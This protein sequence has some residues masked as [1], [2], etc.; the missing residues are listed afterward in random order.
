[1][2][3]YALVTPARN[4][5]ENLRRLGNAL[6]EQTVVPAEWIVVDD[7]STDETGS[8]VEGFRAGRPWIRLLGPQPESSG[9][10]LALGRLTGRDVYAFSR[11]V[12]A[13]QSDADVIVKLDADV[14]F[15]PDFFA[16]LLSE[17]ERDPTLG[18]AGGLCLE[19]IDGEW[20]P[21]HT[22]GDHVRGATRA[23][24]RECLRLVLPLAPRL[25][26]DGI[27]AAQAAIGG[28]TART[29]SDLPFKHHRR[30]GQ[31]DGRW[32]MWEH[33]G[34]AARYMGY[35]LSY[36]VAR[37]VFWA[38]RDPQALA[39]I[40]GW[41]KA[42]ARRDTKYPDPRVRAHI[43]SKQRFRSLPIRAREAA[44]RRRPT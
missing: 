19:L 43:R 13:L 14:S 11:G 20:R 29:V 37:S 34:D 26:W 8:V 42:A 24:R 41:A 7:D 15:S 32:K 39:M 23:Y 16:R 17:F 25:G 30:L 21:H 22:T 10:A 4:E 28:W 33:Q 12:E 44:G 2:L 6:V 3:T 36:L 18:I 35:R 1:M 38:R 40:S 27:D 5:A 9:A 31:R